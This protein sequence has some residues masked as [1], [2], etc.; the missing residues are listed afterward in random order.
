MIA[1]GTGHSMATTENGRVYTWGYGDKGRLGH[2]VDLHSKLSPT[3][4]EKEWFGKK[5]VFLVS[6][7]Y[8]HSA[9]VTT[10]GT[11]YT[12]GNNDPGYFKNSNNITYRPRRMSS[13]DEFDG[14]TV[15]MV[16]CGACYTLV[17][18]ALN[19]LWSWGNGEDNVLGHN[20]T[21]NE[22]IPRQI[23]NDYF[24][25]EKIVT[26]T[27]GLHLSTALTENGNLYAWG[28]EL[29]VDLYEMKNPTM[30]PLD[31][32]DYNCVGRCHKTLSIDKKIALAM[33]LHKTLGS[34][35]LISCLDDYL[36]QMCI[37]ECHVWPKGKI[38]DCRGAMAMLGAQP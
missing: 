20:S 33:G 18:T 26:C 34:S 14:S 27:G 22:E 3:M 5:S 16:S 35:S 12:W 31:H 32:L 23:K 2:G 21:D 7:G 6:G 13:K 9:A 25:G 8:C 19:N 11:L 17:L 30:I 15:V 10:D 38:S 1:A 28:S 36:L 4:I 29:R 37:K 24:K